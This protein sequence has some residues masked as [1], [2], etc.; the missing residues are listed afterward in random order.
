[1]VAKRQGG[2]IG[3]P[4]KKAKLD[5]VSKKVKEVLDALS[6]EDC[7][8][9]GTPAY[10]EGL[11]AAFPLA[12]G[13]GAAKDERHAYQDKV[14]NI[15]L[16][17]LRVTKAKFEERLNAAKGEHSTGESVKSSKE[18]AVTEAEAMLENQ[19]NVEK[20]ARDMLS[21]SK[22]AVKQAKKTVAEATSEV[23]NFDSIQLEKKEEHEEFSSALDTA[24]GT[25]KAGTVEDAKE[26]KSKLN[27]VSRVLRKLSVDEGLC[28]AT[29]S[30]LTKAPDARGSFD[31]TVV[32]QVET[33]LRAHVDSLAAELS[34]GETVKASKVVEQATAQEALDAAEAKVVENQAT[35]TEA[36]AK[37][38]ELKAALV[39]AKAGL[40]EQESIVGDMETKSFYEQSHVDNFKEAIEAFEFLRDRASIVPEAEEE[41]VA[42][43]ETSTAMDE[44]NMAV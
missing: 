42:A 13:L 40:K 28:N 10:R 35:V 39:Q 2:A 21:T 33:A 38:K 4:A 15:V 41:K 18:A 3:R 9:G 8:V 27:T 5:P 36:D 6:H 20:E 44:V 19:K 26:K 24:F 12:V 37:T 43:M 7:E 32:D 31:N 23:D 34:N 14:A 22:D 30:A 16:E 25:L 1:M 17:V 29:P 11:R